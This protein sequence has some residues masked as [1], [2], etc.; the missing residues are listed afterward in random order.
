MT[1]KECF[2]FATSCCYCSVA[3]SWL[4]LCDPMDCSTPSFPVLHHLQ[5]F[6]QT[7]VHWL[8]GAIQPSPPLPPLSPAVNLSQHQGLFQWVGSSTK[9]RGRKKSDNLLQTYCKQWDLLQRT[10]VPL[11]LEAVPL[12]EESLGC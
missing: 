1:Y 6:S 10:F 3:K 4:T 12:P 8:G 11:V 2:I 9:F 5:E 7:C